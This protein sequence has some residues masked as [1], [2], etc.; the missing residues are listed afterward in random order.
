MV[1][2]CLEEAKDVQYSVSQKMSSTP[3]HLNYKISSFFI[4]YLNITYISSVLNYNVFEFF[5]IH[6]FY[7]VSRYSV[8]LSV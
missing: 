2:A 7:Y 3:S 4:V 8:Y 5:Y 1:R 6:W